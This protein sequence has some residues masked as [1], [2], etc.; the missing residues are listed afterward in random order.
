MKRFIVTTSLGAAMFAGTS[1]YAQSAPSA[2]TP[3]PPQDRTTSTPTDQLDDIVVVAKKRETNLQDTSGAITAFSGDA[4]T[5]LGI[6]DVSGLKGL[7]PNV[8]IGEPRLT[9]NSIISIR[10]IAGQD[11]GIGQDE[12]VAVYL[13]GVYLGRPQGQFFSLVDIERI[14]VLKGPQGTLYGRNSTAGAISIITRKPSSQF[15]GTL[16]AGTGNFGYYHARGAVEGG[17]APRLSARLSFNYSNFGGDLT[18]TLTGKRERAS[19]E[20]LVRLV[21]RYDASATGGPTIDLSADYGR[22]TADTVL[23]NLTVNGGSYGDPDTV[24]LDLP[25]RKLH[26]DVGGV[27]LTIGQKLSDAVSL[28]SVTGYRHLDFNVRY[29]ADATDAATFLSAVALGRIPAPLAILRDSASFQAVRSDAYSE[30]L[31]LAG[32]AGALKWMVGAFAYDEK[33]DFDFQV[34]FLA[35]SANILSS[36]TSASNTSTSFAGFTHLEWKL[37]DL[38]ELE[39]GLRYSYERKRMRRAIVATSPAP[40]STVEDLSKSWGNVTGDLTL[41]IRPTTGVLG[42]ITVAQGFKSGGFN[43]TQ[44]G[45][46][47]FNPEKVVSY[48]AGI[49]TDFLDRRAR[50]NLS[51]FHMNYDD[52]QVRFAA[53]IGQITIQNAA[54]ATIDGVEFEA[55][56][57]AAPGLTLGFTGAYLNA[58]YDRYTLGAVDFSGN[59]LNQAPRWS[60]RGSADYDTALGRAGQL[61]LH[62]GYS[63]QSREYYRAQNDL[64]NS[65]PGYENLEARVG[66]SPSGIKGATIEV[67]GKNLTDDRYVGAVVPL[68][69]DLV[70]IGSINR[71]RTYGVDFRFK[72]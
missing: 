67:W 37:S 22:T 64:L 18:N 47:A 34:N 59:R 44:A 20:G 9:A 52:L 25:G 2:A 36:S 68:A 26:R 23:K 29:D 19:E 49:K 27:G 54:K 5:K 10:G 38:F 16:E 62:A 14:E 65:N 24:S 51:V 46:P 42:Y 6:A 63:W 12:P 40:S 32:D 66:F 45:S 28:T 3:P 1:A 39:G 56:G 48:E 13:D 50:L 15:G 11:G 58:R 55:L 35:Q 43:A 57:R 31:R 33:S 41:N 8:S 7:V 72:F 61:S 71:G 4:V 17:I 30:E 53:G 21:T 70:F 60:L 69:N